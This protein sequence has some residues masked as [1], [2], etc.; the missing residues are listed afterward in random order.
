M[1]HDFLNPAPQRSI[2]PRCSQRRLL[3]YLLCLWHRCQ[4]SAEDTV[5]ESRSHPKAIFVVHEVVLQMIL[6]EL[7]PVGGQVAVVE[8][9]MCHVVTDITKYAT[10][11]DGRGDIPI[12]KEYKM[13]QFP[14]WCCEHYQEG[15]WHDQPE[16]V[17]W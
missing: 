10:T 2:A 4:L 6:L 9:V 5:P 3:S 17:H 14:E 1:P 16:S 15:W 13:G 12:P 11:E 8:E 7:S